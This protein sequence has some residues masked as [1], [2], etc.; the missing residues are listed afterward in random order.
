MNKL[1]VKTMMTVLALCEAV[2]LSSCQTSLVEAA[3]MG[4]LETVRL[5][6]AEKPASQQVNHAAFEAYCMGHTAVLKE[7]TAAGAA[8]APES[9]LNKEIEVQ[10]V[11][12]YDYGCE[13]YVDRSCFDA[14]KETLFDSF[15][16]AVSQWMST[17]ETQNLIWA[18][19]NPYESAPGKGAK[20]P[21]IHRFYKRTGWNAAEI[22]VTQK[23]SPD[24]P[25]VDVR[26]ALSFET[27]TQGVF[28]CITQSRDFLNVS[29]GTFS[30]KDSP[31]KEK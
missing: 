10:S 12:F 2:V 21:V 30:L 16:P 24:F 13:H 29:I 19:A 17:D 6:I 26:Y 27:P 20:N 23:A 25:Y 1:T 14:S 18:D 15:W 7:L 8:V 31:V 3:R 22:Y 5:R 28:R 11:S 4:D 9:V